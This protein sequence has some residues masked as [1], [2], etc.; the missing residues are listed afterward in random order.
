MKLLL[1]ATNRETSPF[2]VAPLGAL[3]VAAAARA[4]GHAVTFL[5]LGTEAAPRRA[6]HRA[7]AADDFEVVGFSIRN[8]DNCFKL[9]PRGYVDQVLALAET[10][11]E[12]FSGPFILGG[13]GFSV[14]PR[15]WMQRLPVD[16][17]LVGEGERAVVEMLARLEAG[18][19][20][21]DIAGVI[22]KQSSPTSAF[23]SAAPARALGELCP[24]A[25]ELCR[26]Q[27]YLKRGGFVSV[28]TKRGCP[29]QCVYCVYPRLDGR[30]YRLRPPEMV[31][32][33]VESAVK[34]SGAR[35]YFLVDGVFNEPRAHALAV[36]AALERRRL[37]ARWM[38]FCN[39]V[40][41][42]AEL[43][44]AMARAGCEGVEFGLDAATPKMLAAMRKP[45]GQ[46]EIQTAFK[47]AQ[48]AKLPFAV[49]LLFGGPGET[50]SDVEE[51]Q[52][53]L[54]GCAP[55]NSIFASL[56]IRIY[57]DTGIAEI[58]R[59][60]GAIGPAQDL[61]DPVYYLSS[62]MTDRPWEHLDRIARQREE[63]TSPV[64]WQRPLM[65][66][67]QKMMNFMDVRPQWRDVRGYGRHMRR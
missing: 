14:S 4:A 42:D 6:L 38:A 55:A 29:H 41:F 58:A 50:W 60:E 5:D 52:N 48:D 23:A 25:H 22:A 54:N 61:F 28:Q 65:R 15:G 63:W 32:E 20:L 31:A 47:A 56:G 9:S 17:G 67:I 59:R 30:R 40:G 46:D 1:V 24:P 18:Q 35:H 33:E 21:D 27:N 8:L 44:H 11:R 45:F 37:P 7:L 34:P 64:D 57:E 2:P 26:Y 51:T 12:K 16:W 19:P 49:Y 39:P 43:S 3:C 53:F 13:S 62:A 66:G 10:V 36:C